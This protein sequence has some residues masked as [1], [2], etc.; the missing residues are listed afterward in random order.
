M[1][2]L[3]LTV[4]NGCVTQRRC[5]E[6]FP[7]TVYKETIVKDTVVITH[8]SHFDT[9]F[10]LNGPDTVFLRDAKTQIQVKLVRVRDSFWVHSECPPD[11]IKIEKVRVENTVERVR[12]LVGDHPMRFFWILLAG[13]GFIFSFGYLINAIKK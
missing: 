8:S 5:E 7:A 4:A 10:R 3:L 11:T 9:L 2:F 13:I 6:K 1:M 12:H